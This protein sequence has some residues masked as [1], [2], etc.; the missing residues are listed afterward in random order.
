MVLLRELEV[1]TEIASAGSLAAAG[2]RLNMSPPDMTSMFAGLENRLG[3]RLIQRTTRSLNLTE[4]GLRIRK[5]AERLLTDMDAAEREVVGIAAVLHGR[6]AVT[7]SSSLAASL[8]S[9]ALP[10]FSPRTC[11]R[12]APFS[13]GAATSI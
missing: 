11:G 3:V 6:V 2:R 13:C 1:F 5:S 8:W 4:E 10:S 7:T 9:Q 12:V